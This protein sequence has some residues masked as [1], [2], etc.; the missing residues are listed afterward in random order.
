MTT[1][2]LRGRIRRRLTDITPLNHDPDNPTLIPAGWKWE[3]HEHHPHT[4]WTIRADGV[5]PTQQAA[6][7]RACR[8]IL[9][10]RLETN[11]YDDPAA[12]MAPHGSWPPA[13]QMPDH[14]P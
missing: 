8:F 3:I 5:Q 1:P 12:P 9:I 11:P 2:T 4:G 13:E 14:H 7:N 10:T 6:L